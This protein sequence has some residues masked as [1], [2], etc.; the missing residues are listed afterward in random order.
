[1]IQ[2]YPVG[3]DRAIRAE[4]PGQ[5]APVTET[6]P[7]AAAAAAE[8]IDETAAGAL[9][10]VVVWFAR[11][12]DLPGSWRNINSRPNSSHQ[13]GSSPVYTAYIDTKAI[14]SIYSRRT[15]RNPFSGHYSLWHNTITAYSVTVVVNPVTIFV[16]FVTPRYSHNITS[17]SMQERLLCFS[18]CHIVHF[19]NA[20]L[21]FMYINIQDPSLC[22]S[23]GTLKIVCLLIFCYVI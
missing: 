8:V 11:G 4:W 2:W 16:A 13:T 22:R 7:A 9:I 17:M 3:R 10:V 20:Y 14:S 12:R 6:H 21:Y 19:Y 23:A 1:M 5:R 18:E 15:P